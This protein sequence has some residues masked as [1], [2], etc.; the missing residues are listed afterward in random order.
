MPYITKY[1]FFSHPDGSTPYEIDRKIFV[2]RNYANRHLKALDQDSPVTHSYETTRI[3]IAGSREFLHLLKNQIK[4]FNNYLIDDI[5]SESAIPA[6]RDNYESPQSGMTFF[7]PGLSKSKYLQAQREISNLTFD[8]EVLGIDNSN[9][10]P[11]SDRY[12][13]KP[14]PWSNIK[15][16]S[17]QRQRIEDDIRQ[18]KKKDQLR[19][20][21]RRK[22]KT[23]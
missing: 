22:H 11:T 19:L 4:S 14:P 17:E 16:T 2:H 18:R 1:T 20:S 3:K 9:N 13:P 5:Y 21:S 12:N 6:A 10:S 7:K 23:P 8:N 15:Y